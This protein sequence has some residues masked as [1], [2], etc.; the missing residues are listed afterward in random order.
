MTL[1]IGLFMNHIINIKTSWFFLS[2]FDIS[3]SHVYIIPN[4]IMIKYNFFYH[5]HSL[6]FFN[7][8]D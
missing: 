6:I 7:M 8:H 3:L 2:I 5:H 1:F 4:N